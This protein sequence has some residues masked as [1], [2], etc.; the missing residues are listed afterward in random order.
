LVTTRNRART[1]QWAEQDH[2]CEQAQ[3]WVE[4]ENA[5]QN[6]EMQTQGAQRTANGKAVLMEATEPSSSGVEL[7]ISDLA[8]IQVT[9]TLEHLLRLVPRFRE[10]IP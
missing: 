6:A 8:G 10:G 5:Q 1:E 3:Q 9:M 4:E 7:D 2:V